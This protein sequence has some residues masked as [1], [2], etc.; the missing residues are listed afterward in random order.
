[1]QN[2]MNVKYPNHQPNKNVQGLQSSIQPNH[3]QASDGAQ[4][5]SSMGTL[6]TIQYC[7]EFNIFFFFFESLVTIFAYATPF[8]VLCS[9]KFYLNLVILLLNDW[10]F[11]LRSARV[12]SQRISKRGL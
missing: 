10:N 3:S 12:G 8:Q 5:L 9:G 1:M 11:F 7:V 6:F 2:Q 4:Q